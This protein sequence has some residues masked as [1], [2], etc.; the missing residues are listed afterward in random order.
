LPTYSNGNYAE[1]RDPIYGYV[2][3]SPLE[4]EIIDT[5]TFQRL[6]R[7]RQLAGCHL[8]YPG[9]QHSRFEH[10][11]GAM[12]LAGKASQVIASRSDSSFTEDD[13]HALRL[14]ALL[15]DVGHGPFSH[16]FEEVMAERT[17]FTHEDMTHRIILKTEIGDI[18][19]RHGITRQKLADLAIAR[20]KDKKAYMNDVISGGLSADLM[21]YLPRDSYFTGVEYG[22]VDASRIIN[23]LEVHGKKL[24]LN[25]AAM[26]AFEALMIARFEMFRAVYFHRTVRAAELMLIRS[27]TLADR[28]LGLTDLSLENYLNLTDEVTLHRIRFMDTGS[29]SEFIRARKLA[30]DYFRRRLLKCVYE[31]SFQTKEKF[32]TPRKHQKK[33]RREMQNEISKV[34]QVDPDDIYVDAPVAPSLPMSPSRLAFKKVVVAKS[35]GQ[36]K[37]YSEVSIEKM[38]L[39]STISGYMN[40]VRIYTT[41]ANREKV[42]A[43]VRRI[44]RD[45]GPTL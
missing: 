39:I 19:E 16:M 20:R 35:E 11:I 36:S 18:L 27:M 24:A 45:T 38:P 8:V 21:D 37:K 29:D 1:I 44:L 15:H 40:I 6:R 4:A 32:P 17:S 5:A 33:F 28:Q 43:A 2:F 42:L 12:H 13:M 10:V 9:G 23:S 25:Q 14:A 31:E 30:D 7:I 34:S 22:K 41:E 26:F 3:A